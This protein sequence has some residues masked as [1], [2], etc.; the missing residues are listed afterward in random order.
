[1][2]S[3]LLKTPVFLPSQVQG[4]GLCCLPLKHHWIWYSSYEVGKYCYHPHRRKEIQPKLV[5]NFKTLFRSW[6]VPQNSSDSLRNTNQFPCVSS[7]ASSSRAIFFSRNCVPYMHLKNIFFWS[8]FLGKH[9][10]P[11]K[12]F[13]DDYTY[14]K[15]SRVKYQF[16]NTTLFFTVSEGLGSVRSFFL[17]IRSDIPC[18]G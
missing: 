16:W 14:K 10:Y 1:M 17:T 3:W 9:I 5:A 11:L 7:I 8:L 13:E 18:F 12:N 15:C 2:N 6:A 4:Q